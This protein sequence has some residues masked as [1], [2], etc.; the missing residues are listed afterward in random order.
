MSV[1]NLSK[2]RFYQLALFTLYGFGLIAWILIEW[3][4]KIP[5]KSIF[6]NGWDWYSQ[7]LT[8]LLFGVSASIIAIFII[9]RDFFEKPRKLFVNLIGGLK[10]NYSDI[11]FISLCAGIG[12]ELL[13]RGAIQP[14][15][16]IWL[17]AFVFVLLHG[18]LNPKNWK[19][20]FYGIFM[21]II[22]AGFGYLYEYT[23]ILSAITAHFIIDVILFSYLKIEF[24][25]K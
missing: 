23:G 1:S 9:K 13:F 22:S 19:M 21:V 10:L 25:K 12:E 16:G 6:L 24:M 2:K 5:F 14:W 20:S 11:I 7:I 18:Y 3:V 15:L 17:T 8:G 4:H